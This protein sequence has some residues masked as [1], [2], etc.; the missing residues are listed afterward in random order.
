M[1]KGTKVNSDPSKTGLLT[2]ITNI[3]TCRK[4]KMRSLLVLNDQFSGKLN[5]EL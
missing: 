3:Q 4:E 2:Q 1:V 5:T